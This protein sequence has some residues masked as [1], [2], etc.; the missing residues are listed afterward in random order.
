MIFFH[1]TGSLKVDGY[2][3]LGSPNPPVI[4]STSIPDLTYSDYL[5]GGTPPLWRAPSIIRSLP[6]PFLGCLGDLTIDQEGYNPLDTTV[7]YGV[8]GTCSE[9][10]NVQSASNQYQSAI[11]KLIL[12]ISQYVKI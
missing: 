2:E 3:Q 1:F 5:L 6:P 8:E 7:H 10:V 11:N 4:H 9:K 12:R